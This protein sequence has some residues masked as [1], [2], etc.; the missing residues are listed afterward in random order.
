ME[1]ALFD[2]PST[3]RV[4]AAPVVERGARGQKWRCM[5]SAVVEVVDPLAL[6]GAFDSSTTG[7]DLA[8]A[9]EA[10]PLSP[11]ELE[12]GALDQVAWMLWPHR[13]LEEA[14]DSGA[15]RLEW[16]ETKVDA[17]SDT[18]G[19]LTWISE[20]RLQDVSVLRNLAVRAAPDRAHEISQSV[21]VAWRCAV[22]LYAPIREIPGISWSPGSSDI[23]HVP[24]RPGRH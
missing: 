20:V 24:A 18:R 17:E 1:E 23:R 6:D 16:V 13:G 4:A 7:Y 22:D 9:D 2:L 5:V 12:P 19:T 3:P 15:L 14:L 8:A 10:E 21:E 11:E